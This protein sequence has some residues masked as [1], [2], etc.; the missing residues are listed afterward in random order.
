MLKNSFFNFSKLQFIR[1]RNNFFSLFSNFLSKLIIQLL[2]PF[3][4]IL[5]WGVENFGIWIFVTALPSTFTFL[6]LHFSYATRIEMTIN[7]AKKNY[8]LLNSIFQNGFGL[9]IVNMLIYTSLWVSCFL[10]IEIDI[11]IFETIPIKE[12]K[13]ILFI[14]LSSFYFNIFDSIL[15]TGTSY[16]GKIHIP[17]NI[18]TIFDIFLKILIILSGLVVNNLIYPAIILLLISIL[19]TLTLFYYFLIN[20]KYIK[21]SFKLINF[22]I[23]FKLFKLSLSF[24]SETIVQIIKHNGLTIILGIFYSA[25]II[26]LIATSKT[27]FYFLPIILVGILNHIGIYEYSEAIGKRAKKFVKQNYFKHILIVF[28]ITM[29]FI[30]FSLTIGTKIHNIWTVD[31]YDLKPILLVLIVLNSA[32]VLL[33][34]AI[35]SII[36]SA[37]NFLK[38][39]VC[40]AL[41]SLLALIISYYCLS[42]GYDYLEV[43]KVFLIASLISLSV[44]SYYSLNFYNKLVK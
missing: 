20:K 37:N 16:W 14:I 41:I 13:V 26:G 10:F 24:Y 23:S 1:V 8:K 18:K 25:E 11:K 34:S 3:L 35:G 4:M 21:L 7:N 40:E 19:R 28:F 43:F 22:K 32:F 42:L 33:Q 6:N 39:V 29:V 38:P 36:K 44:Y 9:V 15:T 17:T 2:F 30:I 5:I 27:L 31:A 12:L